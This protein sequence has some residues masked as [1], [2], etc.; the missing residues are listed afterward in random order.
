MHK[1]ASYVYFKNLAAVYLLNPATGHRRQYHKSLA[2]MC[3]KLT[4]LKLITSVYTWKNTMYMYNTCTILLMRY[5]CCDVIL[6]FFR[7]QTSKELLC[8]TFKTKYCHGKKTNF[9]KLVFLFFSGEIAYQTQA[10]IKPCAEWFYKYIKIKG[11]RKYVTTLC[12]IM[13][14]F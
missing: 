4:C 12:R 10:E 14:S 3:D 13:F 9:L 2:H 8:I 5:F 1:F 7:L 11:E 6:D